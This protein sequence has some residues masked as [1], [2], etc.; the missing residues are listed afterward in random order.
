MILQFISIDIAYICVWAFIGSVLGFLSFRYN[1]RTAI[2]SKIKQCLLSISIGLFISLPLYEYLQ[3][4]NEFPKNLNIMLCGIGA[5]GLPD[6]ILT[7]WS[8]LIQAIVYKI[9]NKTI[10]NCD[11]K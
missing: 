1:F 10:D 11:K 6:F 7:H 9:V 8:K 3:W 4:L 5:F 2:V